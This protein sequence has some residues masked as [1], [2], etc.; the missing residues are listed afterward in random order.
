M[1]DILAMRTPS[2]DGWGPLVLILG[3]TAAIVLLGWSSARLLRTLH[4]QEAADRAADRASAQVEAARQVRSDFLA[5]MSHELRTP[6]NAVIGFANVLRKD[7]ERRFTTNDLTYLERIQANGQHLLL[8]IDQILD[9]SQLES[10]HID[11]RAEPV[12][13]LGLV[14]NVAAEFAPQL[15]DRPVELRTVLPTALAPVRTDGEKLRQ[16]LIHLTGNALKFTTEGCIT[17][18]VIANHGALEAMEVSDTGI[19]IPRERLSTV[20]DA[21][22][23][24]ENST[25][26]RYGGTGLGL[27]IARSLAQLIGAELTVD[28]EVGTGTTFR[29]RFPPALAYR[30]PPSPVLR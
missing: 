1:A 4:A 11:L 3:C 30:L 15:R 7:P 25:S 24:G 20:F 26:R 21:F 12:D 27:S 16:I 29:L 5:R 28:S 2:W 14:R 17:I 22:E 9:L 13:V 23:Q 6:L 8:L 19:G 18:T 10:G